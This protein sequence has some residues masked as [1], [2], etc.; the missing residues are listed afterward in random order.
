M[1]IT[2]K[3]NM[4]LLRRGVTEV[5]QAV[6]TDAYCRKLQIT[7]TAG[8]Q[9]VEFPEDVTVRCSYRKADGTR[10]IYDIMPDGSAAGS[11]EGNVVTLAMA[12][13]LLTASG[14]AELSVQLIS[15]EKLL[16]VFP[17]KVHVA[18]L[19]GFGGTSENYYSI[20]G[21]P[22]VTA[23]DNGKVLTVVDGM[24]VAAQA[25]AGTG[26]LTDTARALLI[27]ILR[28]AVYTSDQ[29]AAIAALEEA[30]AKNASGGGSNG[31]SGEAEA[32]LSGISATYSGGDVAVGTALTDLTGVVVVATY[33]DGSTA[34]VTGYTLSGTI[35]EG[36][37]TIVV[38]YGG[39][40][41]TFDVTGVT[42]NGGDEYIEFTAVVRG[43]RGS[44]SDDSGL[45]LYGDDQDRAIIVPVGIYLEKGK[46][47][48][49]SMG[50][51]VPDDPANCVYRM[52]VGTY[53]ASAPGL[54]FAMPV[55]TTVT[56]DN[57]IRKVVASGWRSSDYEFTSTV[58]NEIL[59]INFK[60]N[61]GGDM[62]EEDYATIF[63]NFS[64]KAVN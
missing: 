58:D 15:G 39:K 10:G 22:V 19:P 16:N 61:A 50:S 47:Y 36:R 26:G 37:N 45:V 9:E 3:I 59:S 31:E 8:G 28:N 34:I 38:R 33:S 29:S 54:T 14:M 57:V 21:L 2:H 60:I 42:G 4:D 63:K 62:T 53:E 20:T 30:L 32:T 43:S 17:V 5:I 52:A 27:S 24:W 12:P 64:V 35:A 46:T 51:L 6:Q 56:Y 11:V 18:E 48:V 49:A 40:T 13:Q 23:A 25:Q 1:V 41:T 55:D 7:V 44:K